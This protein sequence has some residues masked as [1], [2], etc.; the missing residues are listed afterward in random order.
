MVAL[1]AWMNQKDLMD[2][3]WSWLVLCIPRNPLFERDSHFG[4]HTVTPFMQTA[5]PNHNWTSEAEIGC[6]FFF[7]FFFSHKIFKLQKRRYS[8]VDI[9]QV[10]WYPHSQLIISLWGTQHF[11]AFSPHL[12]AFV[13]PDLWTTLPNNHHE[14]GAIIVIRV[15]NPNLSEIRSDDPCISLQRSQVE[16][17]PQL[18]TKTHRK[19]YQ[20]HR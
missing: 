10:C 2:L 16:K 6:F 12:P 11:H 18:V 20:I 7:F 14:V 17:T 4:I 8:Q 19:P 5:N 13:G 15:P 9:T 1:D 3:W